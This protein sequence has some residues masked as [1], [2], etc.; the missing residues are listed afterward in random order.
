MLPANVSIANISPVIRSVASNL[1]NTSLD[2]LPSTI[3]LVNMAVEMKQIAKMRA[4]E[5]IQ[6]DPT[7]TLHTDATTKFGRKFTGYQVTT[8]EA[9]FS[10]EIF[11]MDVRSTQRTLDV[12]LDLPS[13]VGTVCKAGDVMDD[14]HAKI[15]ANVKNT[16][17]D[18]GSV[19]KSF[20]SLF[21]SYCASVFRE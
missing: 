8:K 5:A 17:S 12:M 21:D 19:E 1:F 9:S 4:V 7:S 3:L 13:D 15:I 10:L 6:Q 14:A 20:N 11:K 2:R 18:R 16:M